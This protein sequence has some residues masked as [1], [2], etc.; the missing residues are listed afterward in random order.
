MKSFREIIEKTKEYPVKTVA[1]VEAADPTV[2]SAIKMAYEAKLAKAILYG[3]KKEI[4]QAAKQ[5]NFSLK[6][7]SVK[8]TADEISSAKE[9]SLSVHN[10]EADILMKGHI[11][12][13]FGKPMI[14]NFN[15][16]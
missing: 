12:S 9:A 10:K 8:E 16:Y 11:H 1:V 15:L 7:V 5:C 14:K 6:D 3:K 4:E 13:T 2:L